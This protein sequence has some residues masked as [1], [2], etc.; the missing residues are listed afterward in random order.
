MVVGNNIDFTLDVYKYDW[1]DLNLQKYLEQL[2]ILFLF[3]SVNILIRQNSWK[4]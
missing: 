1:F 4:E 3:L 2:K